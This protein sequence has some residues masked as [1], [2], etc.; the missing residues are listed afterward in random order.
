LIIVEPAL[1]D[2]SGWNCVP[3][4][5][6]LSITAGMLMPYSELAATMLLLF[7]DI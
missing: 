7:E 6:S 4:R 1:P 3:K 5:L 2:F